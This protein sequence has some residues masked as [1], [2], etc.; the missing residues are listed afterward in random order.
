MTNNTP[1]NSCTF[2]CWL[3]A[4]LIGLVCAYLIWSSVGTLAALLIAIVL[5]VLAGLALTQ[6]FCR[7]GQ[8]AIGQSAPSS[9]E[10]RQA[11]NQVNKDKTDAAPVGTAS[12]TADTEAGAAPSALEP[13]A[14]K[15]AKVADAHK[16]SDGNDDAAPAK[17]Q[18]TAAPKKPPKSKPPKSKPTSADNGSK[19]TANDAMPVVATASGASVPPPATKT[20]PKS[21]TGDVGATPSQDEGTR[22]EALSAPRGDGADDLKKIKGVGPKLE[23][24]LNDL[25]FYHFD[26]IAKW[27]DA[28]VAWVDQNLKG[29]KGRVSRDKWVSQAKTLSAGGETDFSKKVDDGDVY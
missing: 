14:V 28:E 9:G 24:L 8:D 10:A 11:T 16:G 27:N 26:Q 12:A 23:V 21:D 15:A 6:L 3:V 22:P 13:V 19:Q 2:V 25:G 17:T 18:K 1:S 20:V 5:G 7:K 29:F 4:A